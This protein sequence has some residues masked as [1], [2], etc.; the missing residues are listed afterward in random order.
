DRGPAVAAAE[1]AWSA[2]RSAA[3]PA[4]LAPVQQRQW[5]AGRAPQPA[6]GLVDARRAVTPQHAGW[7]QPAYPDPR[8]GYPGHQPAQ[9]HPGHPHSVQAHHGG[10]P[11]VGHAPGHHGPAPRPP[12]QRSPHDGVAYPGP[13]QPDPPHHLERAR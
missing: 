3:A 6:W 13:H 10:P 12:V 7:S 4:R 9:A 1:R 11:P 2:V 8:A 5:D